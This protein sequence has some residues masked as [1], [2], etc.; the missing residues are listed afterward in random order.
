M[1]DP[2]QETSPNV[3]TEHQKSGDAKKPSDTLDRDQPAKQDDGGR[4]SK[5][6]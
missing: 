2:K 6:L 3:S 4:R 1:S 5:L